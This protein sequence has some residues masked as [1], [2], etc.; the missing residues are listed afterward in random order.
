MELAVALLG[1]LVASASTVFAGI[2]A[3]RLAQQTELMR[4][5]SELSF[6]LDVMARLQ[7]VL[8]AIADHEP[9]H[10]LLWGDTQENLRPHASVQAMLDLLSMANAAVRLLPNFSRDKKDD[11][12]SY[13]LHVASESSALREEVR[14]HPEWWP[15]VT[16]YVA[17][18]CRQLGEAEPV[19]PLVSN[20]GDG[21]GR[22]GGTRRR[23]RRH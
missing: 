1:V 6:N 23:L 12:E 2:Q 17:T 20:L 14:K 10:R 4:A 21:I 16:P 8:F 11:W 15:E 7:D 18:V 9:S 22:R 3:R 5:S 19:L 13:T